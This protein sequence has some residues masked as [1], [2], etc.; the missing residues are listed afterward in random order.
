MEPGKASISV[1]GS[2]AII[3]MASLK[4]AIISK[5][6]NH[7]NTSLSTVKRGGRYKI[8]RIAL[9]FSVSMP[10]TWGRELA[11]VTRTY[12]ALAMNNVSSIDPVGAVGTASGSKPSMEVLKTLIQEAMETVEQ[13]K[14]RALKGDQQAIRQLAAEAAKNAQHELPPPQNTEIELNVKA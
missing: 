1:A 14:A 3:I 6:V 5:Y 2:S 4:M 11:R 8:T 9:K 7:S 12:K 10:I 13:T